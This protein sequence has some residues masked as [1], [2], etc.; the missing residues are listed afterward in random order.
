[1]ASHAAVGIDDDLAASQSTVANGA[2][3]YELPVGLI[4][5]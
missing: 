2:A 3:N 1:M 5:Y 4:W